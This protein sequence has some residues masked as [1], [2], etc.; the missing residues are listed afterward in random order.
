MNLKLPT[1][2]LPTIDANLQ[3]VLQAR[4]AELAKSARRRNT[5]FAVTAWVLTFV[6]GFSSGLMSAA[7]NDPLP[8]VA[9][10]ACIYLGLYL[11]GGIICLIPIKQAANAL[12]GGYMH[13]ATYLT[14]RALRWTTVLFPLSYT[15]FAHT[16]DV[17]LRLM[18]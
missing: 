13:K 1:L 15:V 8:T 2:K 9:A 12:N 17:K 11:L 16:I 3:A 6:G 7:S 18:L 4:G 10:I 14:A 5:T